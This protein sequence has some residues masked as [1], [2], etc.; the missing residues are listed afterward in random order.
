M[1]K[2]HTHRLTIYLDHSGFNTN[3]SIETSEPDTVRKELVDAI[4]AYY[5]NWFRRPTML[6]MAGNPDITIPIP[7]V[8]C[9]RIEKL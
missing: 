7:K 6:T 5:R 8:L 1:D 9:F 3:V 4:H 2:E